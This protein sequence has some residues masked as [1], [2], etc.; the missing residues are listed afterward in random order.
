M[1]INPYFKSGEFACKCGCGQCLINDELVEI[2][3]SVREFFQSPVTIT[4]GNR[5]K[6]HNRT[7]GGSSRSQHLVGTA[8]DIV[9]KDIAPSTV[10]NYIE[11][12]F[13]PGGLGRYEGFTHVDVRDIGDRKPARWIG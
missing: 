11:S 4:S 10:A 13:V 1:V 8:A 12:K 9:V 3:T 6:M 5:C 2:L 7:C